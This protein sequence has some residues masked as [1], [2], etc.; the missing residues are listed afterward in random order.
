MDKKLILAVAGAGKTTL[1]LNKLNDKDRFLIVTYT[2]NNYDDIK[3]AII[4]KFSYI[5]SNIKIY[6]YFVFIYDFCFKPFE[7]NLFPQKQIKTRGLD[8]NK[9]INHKIKEN[10]IAY[11]MGK[12]SKKMYA[13]R[14]AKLCNKEKMFLKIKARLEKY[15]DYIFIDEVQDFAGNDFNFISRLTN[16]NVSSIYVGD[17]YQHT[18]DTSRDG[19]TNVNLH[20]DFKK[21]IMK[22]K[23]NNKNLEIDLHSLEKS[24]RCKKEVCDFIRNSLNISIYPLENTN[25]IVKEL[26]DIKEIGRTMQDDKIIKLFYQNSKKYKGNVENWG[27]SKGSTYDNVCVVLN[28]RT[29]KLFVKNQ[30]NTLPMATRNK[31]YVACTRTKNNLFFINEENLNDYKIK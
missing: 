6:T 16:C 3:K 28:K 10:K 8:F 1:L 25:V 12:D 14:L 18:F 31:L 23:Q 29:Y 27:N 30:L 20:K 19:N 4:N 21:Y 11:Y 24:I 22:F 26:T 17:F 5:P 7:I 9:I 15:F 13:S 2:R